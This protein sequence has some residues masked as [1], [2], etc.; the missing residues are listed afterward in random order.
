MIRKLLAAAAILAAALA[1]TAAH[2]AD[3]PPSYRAKA[4]DRGLRPQGQSGAG[5]RPAFDP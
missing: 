5:S 4:G 2:G 3:D 1:Q